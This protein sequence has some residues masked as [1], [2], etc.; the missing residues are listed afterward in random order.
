VLTNVRKHR[1]QRGLPTPPRI[2]PAS[3]GRWFVGWV[4][5]VLPARDSPVVATARSW[6][7]RV[8]WIRWGRIALAETAPRWTTRNPTA[9]LRQPF[10][11]NQPSSSGRLT[12]PRRR[13]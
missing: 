6:L 4:E 5:S 8:G 13:P 1:A 7:L 11:P 12:S 2:D 10:F 9:P 3:S